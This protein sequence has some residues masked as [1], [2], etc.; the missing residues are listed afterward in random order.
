MACDA[1]Q[2]R[3]AVMCLRHAAPP[4]S[5]PDACETCP[6]FT[7]PSRG[8]GDLI[9]KAAKAVGI[10]PCGGCQRRRE[11]LNRLVPFTGRKE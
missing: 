6:Q 1:L 2:V 5:L 10:K 11:A 4:G 8:A 7:G 3:P 9:A